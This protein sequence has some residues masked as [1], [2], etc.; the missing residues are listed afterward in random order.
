MDVGRKKLRSL[1][2]LKAQAD[3]VFSKWVRTRQE[4]LGA[5]FDSGTGLAT[6]ITCGAT[7]K[8]SEMNAGHFWKR[9]HLATRFDP[10]NCHVQCVRCNNYR[11]GAEAE[12][13]AYILQTYGKWTFDV[14][15]NLHRRVVK[16]SRQD[17]EEIIRKY[18]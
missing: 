16:L 5:S 9:G 2:G 15:E 6:C 1:K 10:R 8:P 4:G 13:A 18:S 3:S 11:G 14:L 7:G 12:H 17:Y